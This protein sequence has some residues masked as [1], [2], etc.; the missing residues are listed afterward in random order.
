MSVHAQYARALR[1]LLMTI[2]PH[3]AD[4]VAFCVDS[5]P[6]TS[7]DFTKDMDTNS[8]LNLFI[9][10]QPDPSDIRSALRHT[11]RTEHPVSQEREVNRRVRLAL[12]YL[13]DPTLR[14]QAVAWTLSRIATDDTDEL[15]AALEVA[16]R[17]LKNPRGMPQDL[18][19]SAIT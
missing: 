2:L 9:A 1:A 4:F 8:K 5:F 11:L 7:R 14:A 19:P 13:S 17:L 18:E 15:F 3:D 10:R 16:A 6:K 12:D